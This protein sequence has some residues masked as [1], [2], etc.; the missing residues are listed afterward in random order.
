M[1]LK[2]SSTMERLSPDNVAFVCDADRRFDLGEV[3]IVS[4]DS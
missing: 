1:V 4:E 2:W 3:V